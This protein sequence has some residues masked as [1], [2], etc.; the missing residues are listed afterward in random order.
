MAK[1]TVRVITNVSVD[2]YLASQ[3]R[4]RQRRGTAGPLERENMELVQSS[5][6][7]ASLFTEHDIP[8]ILREA[9]RALGMR[10]GQSPPATWDVRSWPL[11]VKQAV[12]AAAH[13]CWQPAEEGLPEWDPERAGEAGRLLR[14]HPGLRTAFR[15]ERNAVREMREWDKNRR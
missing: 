14:E 13:R 15:D 9:A 12:M 6:Y 2:E 7:T 11:T 3:E 10:E 4:D 1:R 8:R 5:R